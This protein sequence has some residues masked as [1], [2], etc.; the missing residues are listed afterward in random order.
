MAVIGVTNWFRLTV[1]HNEKLVLGMYPLNFVEEAA[2]K[3]R[4]DIFLTRKRIGSPWR[5]LNY[6]SGSSRGTTSPFNTLNP[7]LLRGGG[8]MTM[9]YS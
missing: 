9:H 6:F 3:T 4:L 1:I 8:E 5:S 2:R 7:V